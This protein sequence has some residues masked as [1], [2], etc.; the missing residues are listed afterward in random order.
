V[1]RSVRRLFAAAAATALILA[2][3]VPALAV[4][5]PGIITDGSVEV[6]VTAPDG[7]PLVGAEVELIVS[8]S[9]IPED[10]P[11]QELSGVTDAA[12]IA[13][14]TGVARADTDGP[15]LEVAAIAALTT[16]AEDDGGCVVTTSY[17]GSS[18]AEAGES[19]AL[20]IQTVASSDGGCVGPVLRGTV[21]GPDGAPFIVSEARVTMT[22]PAGGG[23]IARPF[24]VAGDGS[25]EVALAPW[26]T[27]DDPAQVRIVVTGAATEFEIDDD[28]CVTHSGPR[29]E[30]TFDVA[31]E[32]DGEPEPVA[33]VARI[34]VIAEICGE[35]S[36]AK[37]TLPATDASVG[38]ADLGGTSAAGGMSAMGVLFGLVVLAVTSNR[39]AAR[40]RG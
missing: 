22:A 7:A 6:T 40:R 5:A 23:A 18:R 10:P 20:G 33:L 19:V 13:T 28:G 30:D 16:E 11:V 38:S 32:G 2:S 8:A 14:F 25:F 37:P 12:G 34:V 1:V 17:T 29:A 15:L 36:T 3:T 26:G 21:V 39:I 31:L 27:P 9:D 4:E 35:V 24:D